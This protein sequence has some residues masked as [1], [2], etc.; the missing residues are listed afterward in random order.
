MAL[1]SKELA[2]LRESAKIVARLSSERR[3]A[4]DEADARGHEA[5]SYAHLVRADALDEL[6]HGL[7]RELD[8]LEGRR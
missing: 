2:A 1:S 8:F 3:T 5:D 4:S 7:K 6:H